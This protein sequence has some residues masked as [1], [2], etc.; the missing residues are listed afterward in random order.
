MEGKSQLWTYR[1][2]RNIT[3]GR[4]EYLHVSVDKNFQVVSREVDIHEW[5]EAD[6]EGMSVI[7]SATAYEIAIK[8]NRSVSNFFK[9]WPRITV[10]AFSLSLG[11]W[12]SLKHQPNTQW[13]NE[14]EN[15]L[16]YLSVHGSAYLEE[17]SHVDIYIDGVTG[18]IIYVWPSEIKPPSDYPWHYLLSDPYVCCTLVIAIPILIIVIIVLA[19]RKFVRKIIGVE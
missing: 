14:T 15:P 11:N 6:F 16:W 8:Y 17:G 5:S 18:E 4:W 19:I 7:D 9:T 13:I 12:E 1:Y 10:D 2:I 3:E